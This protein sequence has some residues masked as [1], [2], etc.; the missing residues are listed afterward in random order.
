M[1][2]K[3]VTNYNNCRDLLIL[4]IT[5]SKVFTYCHNLLNGVY[6]L[7]KQLNATS[8]LI[9]VKSE[10]SFLV[11]VPKTTNKCF[12]KYAFDRYKKELDNTFIHTKKQAQ[13]AISSAYI[14]YQ[15]LYKQAQYDYYNP[16]S[17]NYLDDNV[18]NFKIESAYTKYISVC[19]T[20]EPFLANYE[21]KDYEDQDAQ[22]VFVV[23]FSS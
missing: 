2:A 17:P 3:L 8:L 22:V 7:N 9:A 10:S 14:Q 16:S 19:N 13:N 15:N 4:E 20:C 6:D 11:V 12:S 5:F 18:F 23:E 1:Q 21:V